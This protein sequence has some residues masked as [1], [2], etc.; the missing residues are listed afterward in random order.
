MQ[1]MD[2][3]K[4]P[5]GEDTGHL[6]FSVVGPLTGEDVVET[7]HLVRDLYERNGQS[8][9]G[10]LL[11]SPRNVLHITSMFFDPKDEAQTRAVY[12][13]YED[14]VVELGKHN[15]IPYRTNIQHMDLVAE[16]LDFNDHIQMRTNERIKDALDPNGILSPGK[17][18][19]W[20]A[21]LR[22]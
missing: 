18:G 8:Y 12:A 21:R 1:L 10:G 16:Q 19:I 6:D 9:I 17:Q 13:A 22:G 14:M 20:P 5:Y 2:L 11:V 3:F 15:K 7:F 4:T